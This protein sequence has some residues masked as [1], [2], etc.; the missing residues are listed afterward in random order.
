MMDGH[1]ASRSQGT[2][3]MQTT[4]QSAP[5]DTRQSTS[6]LQT[7]PLSAALGAEILGVDLSQPL[8]DVLFAQILDCWHDNAIILFR[9][10]HLSEDDQVRFARR[11]GP[12]A[13]VI[14]DASPPLTRQ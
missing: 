7:R 6:A 2:S 11:F 10:Q 3:P 14:R 13:R 1:R 12:L 8:S 4:T 5:S 9:D